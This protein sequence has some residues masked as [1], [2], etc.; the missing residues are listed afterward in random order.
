MKN[1]IN[2][3]KNE[4]NMTSNTG[5]V[6]KKRARTLIEKNGISEE[7]LIAVIELLIDGSSSKNWNDMKVYV[8]LK[9]REIEE[10]IINNPYQDIDK[11]KFI[12]ILKK[13]NVKPSEFKKIINREIKNSLWVQNYPETLAFIRNNGGL[14]K[15]LTS[16]KNK[17]ERVVVLPSD[18]QMTIVLSLQETAEAGIDK[19]IQEINEFVRLFPKEEW[20]E[21]YY[22][23][24]NIITTV[25]DGKMN[26]NF[27]FSNGDLEGQKVLT[28][29]KNNKKDILS[30]ISEIGIIKYQFNYDGGYYILSLDIKNS[31]KLL[32]NLNEIVESELEK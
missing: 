26:N 20:K 13:E 5:E 4:L 18:E 22:C 11:D 31:L 27:S 14:V 10:K 23:I 9:I 16:T 7:T 24:V 32:N 8:D 3:I 28:W 2:G 29:F 21:V 6:N 15:N 25:K 30:F 1:E 19:L 12:S 17:P